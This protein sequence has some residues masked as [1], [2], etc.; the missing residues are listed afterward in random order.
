MEMLF[1]YCLFTNAFAC[2]HVC[3]YVYIFVCI[4]V[5]M[6]VCM[7]VCRRFRSMG[8]CIRLFRRRKGRRR[9]LPSYWGPGDGG[10]DRHHYHQL[11]H[12][13]AGKPVHTY[14]HTYIQCILSSDYVCIY[15]GFGGQRQSR[16]LL[17]KFEY[18]NGPVICAST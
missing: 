6:Y 17:V 12:T 4:Y 18:R 15:I 10:A 8:N 7:Y 16:S 5:C 3:M 2:M 13:S 14:I 9:S 11:P 1:P